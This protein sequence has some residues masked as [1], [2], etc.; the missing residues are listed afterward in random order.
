MSDLNQENKPP[1]AM[2][3]IELSQEE[4]DENF[5]IHS[6]IDI[7][8]ILRGIMQKKSLVTLYFGTKQKFILTSI[9]NVDKNNKEIVIDYGPNEELGQQILQA[10]KL[11]FVTSENKVKIEFVCNQV[12]KL[13]FEG[14]DAF[15]VKLPTSL[16]RMQRRNYFR[17]ATPVTKPL[18][19]IVPIPL[20][21]TDENSTNTAA[22]A[23]ITLLDIS[24]GGIAVID[25]HPVISFDP[26][27]VFRDCQISLPEVGIITVTIKVQNTYE[28]TLR[29]NLTCK[30]AGCE[31]IALPSKMETMIQRY[32]VRQE[33]IRK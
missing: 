22:N 20:D 15:A 2:S 28:V 14:Q 10:K 8:Y 11:I 19:C 9:L 26:K 18:V 31:F 33:Q 32:I 7:I 24:C 27:K 5:R 23:E 13:G 3:P 29:N 4:I 25:H 17:I 6:E 12:R 21:E 30:K 16:V 1:E